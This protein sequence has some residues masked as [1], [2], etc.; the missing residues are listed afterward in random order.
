MS[1]SNFLEAEEAPTCPGH[2]PYVVEERLCHFN[3]Q[4]A[5]DWSLILTESEKHVGI[6]TFAFGITCTPNPF[7]QAIF[8]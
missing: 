1:A 5:A 3:C 8:R 4:E 2:A 6:K 7:I